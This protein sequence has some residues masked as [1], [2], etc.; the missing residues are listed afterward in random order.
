ML[1]K[2]LQSFLKTKMSSNWLNFQRGGG[3]GVWFENVVHK[4]VLKSIV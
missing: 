4:N 1:L 2:V 3:S